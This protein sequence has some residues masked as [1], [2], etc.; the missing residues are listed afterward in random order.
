MSKS[1]LNWFEPTKSR[2]TILGK[3]ST[4]LTTFFMANFGLT[5]YRLDEYYDTHGHAVPY[6]LT[7]YVTKMI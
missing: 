5:E 3:L 6:P 4:K 2:S 1:N 7:H